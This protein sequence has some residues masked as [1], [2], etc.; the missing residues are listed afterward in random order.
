MTIGGAVAGACG[1]ASSLSSLAFVYASFVNNPHFFD[2]VTTHNV[3][4][5]QCGDMKCV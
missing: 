4:T 1:V 3:K 5:R 2:K